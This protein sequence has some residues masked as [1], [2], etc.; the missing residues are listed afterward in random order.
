MSRPGC[1]VDWSRCAERP[2]T[3]GFASSVMRRL[4]RSN[5]ANVG[6]MGSY[7]P[8]EKSSPWVYTCA[9]AFTAL[10]IPVLAMYSSFPTRLYHSD[11]R[12]SRSSLASE[13]VACGKSRRAPRV[14]SRRTDVSTTV[15]DSSSLTSPQLSFAFYSNLRRPPR[16][17]G[18]ARGVV[19]LC[20]PFY[21]VVSFFRIQHVRHT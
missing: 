18:S 4:T 13:S 17:L 10:S 8:C 9:I 6:P 21:I 14:K 2:Q 12:T 5:K 20:L 19:C 3:K 1:A 11:D 15:P 16:S 7:S